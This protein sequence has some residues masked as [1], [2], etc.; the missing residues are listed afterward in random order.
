MRERNETP[1]APL[2]ILFLAVLVLGTAA[3]AFAGP[4]TDPEDGVPQGD[5][6]LAKAYWVLEDTL[7]W[8]PGT[9]P[10][11]AVVAL[12]YSEDGTLTLGDG[13]VTG[14]NFALT[15][16]PDPAGLPAAVTAKFPH[17]AG[18]QAF[19]IKADD[20]DR[21]P[22]V[23]KGQIAVS[24]TAG[25]GTPIDATAAQIPGVLDDL[26]P[27]DG[28][29]GAEIVPGL[30]ILRVW[31]PTAQK[32]T[33]IIFDDADPQTAGIPA[34]MKQNKR[35]G[36]W[37]AEGGAD[38][39]GKYYLYEVRVWAPSTGRIETHRVTD[40]YS[41][42]LSADS[43]RTQI[44]D[45]DDPALKPRGWDRM[46]KP[47]LAAP[48][49]ISIY[50]LHV[51]DFSWVDPAVAGADRG[52][53][54][55][56]ADRWSYGLRHLRLLRRWGLTH[57]NLL[58]AFDFATV[59]ERREDQV[60][61][62]FDLLASYPPD[63]EMQQA[64][65]AAIEDQDG[66]NQGYDPWHYTVPEG[67]YSSDP[68]GPQRI[69][70]FRRMVQALNRNALRVVM[71]VVYSHTYSAGQDAG[72]VLDK[73]V[74][75]YYH[76]L[77][78]DGMIETSSCCP[79]TA[80]E[81]AMMEKLMIDSL[82]TWARDYKVDGFRFDLMG[83]HPKSTMIKIRQA[84]DA[85][86]LHGSGVDGTQ[87]YLYG[88]GWDFGE[89]AG[90]AR[91]EQ[92]TQAN[93]AG[94]GIGSFNDRGRDAIRGGG[95]AGG[96][97][98][99]GFATGL[100]YDPN[101]TDQG[102]PEDQAERL[103]LL[104]DWIRVSL[105]GALKNFPL[106][107]RDGN[108]VLGSQVDYYGQP[109]GYALDP[110]ETVNYAASHE[111]ETF[112]DA[113]QLKA[114]AGTAMSDRVRVQNMANS[115]IALGQGIPFFH[116]GQDMLRSKSMDRDSFNSG[117]WF[118]QLDFTYQSNNWGGGL[119]VASKN[120]DN[121]P[122]LEP[123][124]A[125]PLLLP[126]P[127]DV[128]AASRHML[129][130][131]RIRRSSRLFRLQN[132]TEVINR[133]GFL[134]TGPDQVP[135]LIVM[136][137]ADPDGGFDRFNEMIVVLFNA[138]DDPLDFAAPSLAGMDF[139]LHWGHKTSADPVVKTSS[140]AAA[141]TFSV[142]ARTTA[143]FTARRAPARQIELLIGDVERLVSGGALG[144]GQGDAL[145]SELEGALASLAA[146]QTRAVTDRFDVFAQKVEAYVSAGILTAELGEE[147]TGAAAG[148]LVQP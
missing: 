67:S 112:F 91:F 65:V 87:I 13:G 125:D 141:S 140:F 48:E 95:P 144:G 139:D 52:T 136:T 18:Y 120:Q 27:Y 14:G 124:L 69:L 57:V 54:N 50:E 37:F 33:P 29:L 59:P 130:M 89:V 103:K 107:D 5:L 84:M 36:V 40:P 30:T 108:P 126:G 22:Q 147:L 73:L 51:R 110:Q 9:L 17:I 32:V 138:T 148:V 129:E 135:G 127:G 71:D 114:P 80:T 74:P 121:W 28:P 53:F 79:N 104:A 92:A 58:P 102:S 12:H 62:D 6:A 81:H 8:N 45:L 109:A 131:L 7:A 96:L 128:K 115:L 77:N 123:L 3:A 90:G 66:F 76:R 10:G 25:D 49:D 34:D 82:V 35:T 117:D 100:Y 23:L 70:E 60:E 101:A 46:F 98:E 142:P 38:W 99:Q 43:A 133:L 26:F 16:D 20:L 4:T 94:T 146:G 145:F 19:K 64:A 78:A 68:D 39:V 55:A 63:S 86:T 56:L 111:Y 15:L 97:Q 1:L 143:A 21:V 113:L 116:A 88:E 118:N 44:V 106:I 105:A 31:A 83:H 41:L 134:N 122:V 93:M 11:D 42:S 47:R 75:G 137:L 85:L 72:S 61:L 119:P 24:A 132:E 2:R